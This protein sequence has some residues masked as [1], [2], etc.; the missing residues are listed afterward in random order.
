MLRICVTEHGRHCLFGA[1]PL[2]YHYEILLYRDYIIHKLLI[3]HTPMDRLQRTNSIEIDCHWLSC[4]FKLS[5]VILP[6]FCPWE[7][8]LKCVSGLMNSNLMNWGDGLRLRM[9]KIYIVRN[10]Y[11]KIISVKNE[12]NSKCNSIIIFSEVYTYTW[13][14]IFLFLNQ[15]LLNTFCFGKCCLHEIYIENGHLF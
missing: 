7:D 4:T 5:S 15:F 13:A 3:S 2:F 12:A 8:D 14:L 11:L 10:L 1:K 6:T 9:A